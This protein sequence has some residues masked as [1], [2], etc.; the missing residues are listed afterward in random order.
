MVDLVATYRIQFRDGMTF[1]RAVE[2]VPYLKRLGISHLYAS[3]IFTAVTGSTHGYDVTNH[4]EIDPAIGGAE[5]LD[6]LHDALRRAGMG[7]ILDIVPNHMAASLENGWWRSVLEHGRQSP[8]AEHFDIDWSERLTLPILGRDFREVLSSGELALKAHAE[9]GCLVL[10]YFDNLIPLQPATYRMIG[11][12]LSGEAAGV[13]AEAATNANAGDNSWRHKLRAIL[14]GGNEASFARDLEAISQDAAFLDRLHDA[15]P[16]RLTFWKDARRHLSYRR[17]FEVTGLVGV[18]VEDDAV[19]DDVHRL[20]LDLVRAGKVDGLRIDHVDG[21]ANPGA[22]LQRLRAEVG[23]KCP[24]FVEKILGD[25]EKLPAEWPV[26]GTTGYEFI[27]ALADLFVDRQGAKGMERAYA[28][29]TG[30]ATS[31][32]E[33][34]RDA[35]LLILRRNFEGEFATL[36][37][38]AEDLSLQAGEVHDRAALENAIAE[39]IIAFPVYRTYGEADGLTQAD[40]QTLLSVTKAAIA[41]GHCE[42][43][44]VEFVAKLLRAEADVSGAGQALALRFR[45]KFQQLTG[46]VM[47]KAV[48]DTLFYRRNPLIAINEVG[49]HPGKDVGSV[50]R[51]HQLMRENAMRP[52]GLLA[53]ATHDTKRGEDARARLYALSEQPMVWAEAVQRWS[54]MNADHRINIKGARAPEAAVEWLLYQALAGAW[55]ADLDTS[56]GDGLDSLAGRLLP[57]VEKA[58]REAKLRTDWLDIDEGYEQAVLDYA[59]RLLSASSQAFLDDFVKTLKPFIEAG[60]VNSLSQALAKLT[61][62]GIPDFYQGAEG[63]DFSLVDPDNR[64][65]VDYQRLVTLA[66][67]SE[68]VPTSD[69]FKQLLIRKCLECRRAMPKLFAAG[70]YVPLAVS[71]PRKEMTVAYLREA[72]G[73]A[74]LCVLSRMSL[75]DGSQ[76]GASADE[77]HIQLPA[78]FAYLKFRNVLTGKDFSAGT[79]V[80]AQSVLQ[81][82]PV[83]LATVE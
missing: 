21:L 64:R 49:S 22:Y 67:R 80:S 68:A 30:S 83:A 8:F 3:P 62:P 38:M 37:S 69:G 76:A 26:S 43:G 58:L 29:F 41:G 72:R 36:T 23:P 9:N 54:G 75:H 24:I 52:P 12:R 34:L 74:A 20:T 6:R 39:I 1:D 4:N 82:S 17:F 42:A 51:F 44:A 33:D 27:S 45:T 65:A 59:A 81:G 79:S 73:A 32:D 31:V 18:R 66:E 55:P 35:K 47:A 57:Y 28:R 78:R 16:W 10:A 77:T 15:Q 60:Q 11:E 63:G 2:I 25:G 53:T 13:L 56:D 46:P 48:E 71:G 61:A 7:L 5:G 70:N 19:F 14:R 40:N 50:E